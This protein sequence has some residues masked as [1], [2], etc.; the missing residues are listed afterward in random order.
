MNDI[1][2][3]HRGNK[4]S[5]YPQ[6]EDI[7]SL[8]KIKDKILNTHVSGIKGIENVIVIKEDDDWIIQTEGSNLHDVLRVREVDIARTKTNDIHQV[9]E[10]LG[11]EAA[12]N[13]ILYESKKTLDEQGLDVDIR[14]LLLLADIMTIDG[15]IRDIGRYGVSGK[16]KSVLARANFEET[17]KH[18][19]NASFY[20]EHD[21][22]KGIIEN[23]IIGQLAPI[24]TGMIE[25]TVDFKKMKRR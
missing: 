17:K 11:I 9:Y 15:E 8:R 24:G 23:I 7:V 20:G 10:V 18:L 25:L 2:V 16:K 21:E 4:I 5:I 6:K 1:K 13:A 22:L 3:S 19:I 14:H 12:R